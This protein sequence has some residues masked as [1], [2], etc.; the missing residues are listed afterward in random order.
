VKLLRVLQERQVERLG[1]SRPIDIN[2]RVVAATNR[3]LERAVAEG[4]FREDLYYRL[5]VFPI[6]VPPLRER[7]EDIPELVRHFLVRFAAEEG[8]RIRA[9]SAD[10]LGVL[11][12]HP[13][14]GNVRQLENA[15][16][17]AVVLA[18][19]D[20]VGAQEFPQFALAATRVA[21]PAIV[22]AVHAA[23]EAP[24]PTP[25][26]L[27]EVSSAPAAPAPAAAG[28]ALVLTDADGHARPLEEIEAEVIRSA[29]ARYRG[30]MSEVAR[31]LRIGRSTLYRKLDEIGIGAGDPRTGGENVASG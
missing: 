26:I 8:K 31:R 15:V 5:N 10:A 2:V 6:T 11:N 4:T 25:L 21:A 20:E 30:Q 27:D 16:F 1:S 18:D 19:G 12:A 24:Q 22:P 7:P 23:H 9:V 14:P 3:D 29:I 17:R 13:W 28:D